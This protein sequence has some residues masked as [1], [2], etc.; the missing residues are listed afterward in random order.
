MVK[1]ELIWVYTGNSVAALTFWHGYKQGLLCRDCVHAINLSSPGT[2]Q[3]FYSCFASL[4]VFALQIPECTNDHRMNKQVFLP[5]TSSIEASSSHLTWCLCEP[6]V[7]QLSW[8]ED[9]SLWWIL[10]LPCVY[11]LLKCYVSAV[12]LKRIYWSSG[13]VCIHRDSS[14]HYAT[15]CAIPHVYQG[16]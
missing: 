6:F 7:W 12:Y 3:E 5:I 8:V 13:D 10:C 15:V 16:C 4:S 2:F 14:F 1:F 11:A 9:S